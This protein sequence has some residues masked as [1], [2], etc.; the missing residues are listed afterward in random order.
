MSVQQR[1][2]VK[3]RAD[4]SLTQAKP[5]PVHREAQPGR[6]GLEA[7]PTPV[8]TVAPGQT[9]TLVYIFH[10]A[11]SL[12]YASHVSGHYQAGMRGTLACNQGIGGVSLHVILRQ[13][14]SKTL[15]ITGSRDLSNLLCRTT[16]DSW[17]ATIV[18]DNGPFRKA[19]RKCSH[20]VCVRR[21]RV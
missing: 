17:S 15:V 4:Q 21:D 8:V 9:K 10:R 14:V 2:S 19:E 18:G 11:G 5:G 6:A 13:R 16:P 3:P 7:D 12:I 1:S 20:W